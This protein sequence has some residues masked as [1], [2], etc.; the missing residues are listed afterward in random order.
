MA[1]CCPLAHPYDGR[2]RRCDPPAPLLPPP[3]LTPTMAGV[4][5]AI[6]PHRRA[7][8]GRSEFTSVLLIFFSFLFFVAPVR[9]IRYCQIQDDIQ[10]FFSPGAGY[11]EIDDKRS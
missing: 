1:P 7:P 10:F 2:R 6:R 4:E 3:S 11:L 5:G 9:E 8:K